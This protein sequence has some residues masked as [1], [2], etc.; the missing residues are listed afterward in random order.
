MSGYYPPQGGPPQ[1]FGYSQQ[2]PPQGQWGQPPNMGGPPPPHMQQQHQ[3]YPQQP[4]SQQPWPPQAPPQAYNQGPTMSQQFQQGPPQQGFGQPPMGPP[5]GAQQPFAQGGVP[6]SGYGNDF[7]QG[8]VN[9][10]IDALNKAMSGFRKDDSTII[11]ILSKTDP[12]YPAALRHAWAQRNSGKSLEE[13]I[14]SS[15]RSH[16]GDALLQ[17]VRGPLLS[18]V[19]NVKRSI[20]GAGTREDMLNDVLIGR[21]NA[22]MRAIKAKYQEVFKK[23]MDYDVES[24]LSLKTK[25][26]FQLI[27]RGSRTDESYP[28][29]PMENT[30][31]VDALFNAMRSPI[32][33]QQEQV[34][35]ILTQRSDNQIRA[36]TH[37]YQ[38]KYH[39]S[40]EDSIRSSFSGHMEDALILALLRATDRAKADANALE[41]AMKGL[42]T[43]DNLLVNRTVRIHWDRLHLDQVK[44]AYQH[45]FK[46]DLI[47]RV[48]G[49]TSGD[50]RDCLVACLT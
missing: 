36:I 4:Y 11:R 8:N 33:T 34:F 49:E 38:Q 39:K 26:M 31:D 30:R 42:G 10:D 6:S 9:A 22:D 17:L 18:D 28:F 20:A 44:K 32:S 1:Q 37:E 48:R 27:M 12:R 19:H 45:F 35:T 23:P 7:Y 29:N 2:L 15:F 40:L 21:S 24:D 43:Q 3:Q 5:M 14:D 47:S 16:Y 13:K 41:N 25:T 50:Y 46:K